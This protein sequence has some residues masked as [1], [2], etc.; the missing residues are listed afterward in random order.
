MYIY[1]YTY[2]IYIY[3]CMSPAGVHED[4]RDEK[5]TGRFGWRSMAASSGRGDLSFPD[6][7]CGRALLLPSNGIVLNH[8]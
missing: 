5:A 6:H 2:C 1:I 7:M 4:K 8:S 3:I